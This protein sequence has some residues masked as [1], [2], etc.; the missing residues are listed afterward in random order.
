LTLRQAIQKFGADATRLALADSGDGIEDANLEESSANAA[1][2]RLYELKKWAKDNLEDPS[3][4]D[5]EL[6]FFDRLFENDMNTLVLETRQNYENTMYKLALKTGFFDLQSSRDWY[7]ENC[8][9]AGIGLHAKLIRR[10]VELQALLLTPIAPHW[11]DS[12]WQELLREDSSIQNARYPAVPK[13]DPVLT[14]ACEYV[15]STAS[16]ISQ[17]E[18]AQ[19]KRLQK[20][21]QTS[22]DPTKGKKLTIF[23]ADAFPAWQQQYRNTLREQFKSTGAVDTKALAG[24]INKSDLKK[25]MPFIQTLK[26]RLDHG[27][28]PEQVLQ[29]RLPFDEA[30]TLRETIPGIKSTVK[31]LELVEIVRY[32]EGEDTGELI[33]NGNEGGERVLLPPVAANAV[34]GIPAFWLSDV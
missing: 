7:R 12:V 19:T 2:L 18:A 20:S 9:A 17:T 30:Q 29:E 32:I 14:G 15:K 26:K 6:S 21:K 33:T 5:G 34:P 13:P 23:V 4:R 31:R 11:A 25:A 1:I 27:E 10:F 3:L 16:T 22:F 8:R 24:Q 28:K